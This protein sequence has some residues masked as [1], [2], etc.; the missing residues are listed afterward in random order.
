MGNHN[1]V[2]KV[3]VGPNPPIHMHFSETHMEVSKEKVVFFRLFAWWKMEI[4]KVARDKRAQ[5]CAKSQE[6]FLEFT[7]R[8]VFVH[9]YIQACINAKI[10]VG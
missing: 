10:F 6:T 2:S 3:C 4:G 7:T 9:V 8:Q 5:L 1:T